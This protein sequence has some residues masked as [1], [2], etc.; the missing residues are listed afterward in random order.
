[1]INKL[2]LPQRARARP[3]PNKYDV[4]GLP[5]VLFCCLS[6]VDGNG[7]PI[8]VV[9]CSAD[10]WSPFLEKTLQIWRAGRFE[11]SSNRDRL[12]AAG[13]EASRKFETI[14]AKVDSD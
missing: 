9:G 14:L 7:N 10:S 11:A 8:L 2:I 6:H 3:L 13:T 4:T 1:M 12:Y 5:S